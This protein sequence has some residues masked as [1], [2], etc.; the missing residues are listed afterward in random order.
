M[1]TSFKE[2]YLA[3]LII[4]DKRYIDSDL[5]DDKIEKH[6]RKKSR[7]ETLWYFVDPNDNLKGYVEFT[8][9]ESEEIVH[10]TWFLAPGFGSFFLEKTLEKLSIKSSVKEVRL[11]VTID[12]KEDTKAAKARLNLYFSAGFTIDRTTWDREE[13]NILYFFMV[14][15]M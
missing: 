2:S 11:G 7:K 15:N 10:V 5:T 1:I 6:H 3:K 8:K 14:R 12:R 13:D 9:N 4:F